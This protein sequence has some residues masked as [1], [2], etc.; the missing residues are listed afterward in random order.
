MW[1]FGALIVLLLTSGFLT[2]QVFQ[3]KSNPT[4]QGEKE[5]DQIIAKVGKLVV[6]PEGETPTLATVTDPEKLK[7]QPFFAKAQV[8]YKVLL[9]TQSQKAILYDPKSNKIVEIAPINNTAE[10]A[11]NPEGGLE[12]EPAEE[13]P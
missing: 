13:T 4:I 1:L 8:G 3:L 9:Y 5:L 12:N 11:P 7:N 6:L 10:P 2:Y